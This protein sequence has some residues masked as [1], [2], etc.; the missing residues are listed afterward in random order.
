MRK[1]IGDF[2]A[3]PSWPEFRPIVRNG[4]RRMNNV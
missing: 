3:S 1:F 4:E 2:E